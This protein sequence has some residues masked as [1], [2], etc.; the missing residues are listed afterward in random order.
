MPSIHVKDIKE[1]EKR[2]IESGFEI[3]SAELAFIKADVGGV[4]KVGY[5]S[6]DGL[7]FT[8]EIEVVKVRAGP[9]GA[10]LGLGVSSGVHNDKNSV[11]AQFLG[12]GVDFGKDKFKVGVN[13]LGS[14]AECSIM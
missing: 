14:R 12:T 13:V 3:T 4:G 7:G 8:S 2:E 1:E 10:K 11:G 5:H 6:K 9:V